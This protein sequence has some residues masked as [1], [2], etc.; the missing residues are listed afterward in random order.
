MSSENKAR[1]IDGEMR[2]A[3]RVKLDISIAYSY[4]PYPQPA[5]KSDPRRWGTLVDISERGLCFRAR[6]HFFIQRI[7]SLYLKLSH[8]TS[9]IKMLGKIVWVRPEQDGS[10][11]VGVQFIGTLPSDWQQLVGG[12]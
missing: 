6:D 12:K 7:I 3:E 1:E 8:E 5:K 9:G 10:S 11:R 4:D 2:S